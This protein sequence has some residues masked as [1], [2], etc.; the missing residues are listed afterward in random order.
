M[1]FQWFSWALV[2][3]Y[4][5]LVSATFLVW[6][7]YFYESYGNKTLKYSRTLSIIAILTWGSV[8]FANYQCCM[9]NVILRFRSGT[10]CLMR[11]EG[12]PQCLSK[13]FDGISRQTE[14]NFDYPRHLSSL[15]IFSFPNQRILPRGGHFEANYRGGNFEPLFYEYYYFIPLWCVVIVIGFPAVLLQ[16]Y[17]RSQ[18]YDIQ[19]KKCGYLLFGNITGICPECGT[20]AKIAKNSGPSGISGRGLPDL[21]K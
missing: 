7:V 5:M 2:P 11:F 4:L 21:D 10:A 12:P 16:A 14:L 13:S 19:C 9:G 8:V 3:C 6:G 17:S 1:K 18:N 15:G 20:I